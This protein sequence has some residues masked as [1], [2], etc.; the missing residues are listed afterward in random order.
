MNESHNTAVLYR[1]SN[2]IETP[3][4]HILMHVYLSITSVKCDMHHR[5]TIITTEASSFDDSDLSINFN[6]SK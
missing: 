1:T 5:I 4:I 2:G 6:L 3:I